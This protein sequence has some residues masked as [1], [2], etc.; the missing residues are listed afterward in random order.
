MCKR[1][2][3]KHLQG[4]GLESVYWKQQLELMPVSFPGLR[5]DD[6]VFR[7]AICLR[8]A[9]GALPPSLVFAALFQHYLYVTGLLWYELDRTCTDLAI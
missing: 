4:A 3:S 5:V 6:P 8:I 7:I 2:Y 9:L 1:L